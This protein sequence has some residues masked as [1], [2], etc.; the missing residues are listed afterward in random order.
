MISEHELRALMAD[1]E[2]DRIE[3]TSP[4]FLIPNRCTR[5]STHLSFMTSTH[6]LGSL[7]VFAALSIAA[8]GWARWPQSRQTSNVNTA[9]IR[10]EWTVRVHGFFWTLES[11]QRGQS[12]SAYQVLAAS[13]PER[14]AKNQG[15]LW[16]SGQVSSHDSIQIPYG[17]RDLKS[18]QAVYWKV[19]VWDKAGH[20]SAWSAPAT[21]TMGV[22]EHWSARWIGATRDHAR[23]SAVASVIIPP[24]RPAT[25]N[26]SG[27][28]SIWG[29][30]SRFPVFGCFSHAARRQGRLWLSGS[31]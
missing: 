20:P 5:P 3:R 25:T 21:W 11:P 8:T 26:S 13:T 24:P 7:L 30:P 27:S 2:S 29:N 28:R 16:D 9:P 10:S 15:D 22:L 12:Q 18:S 14:L 17:G 31:L 4:G 6:R 23:D 19:R 1:M